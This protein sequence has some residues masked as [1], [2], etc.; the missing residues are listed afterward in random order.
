MRVLGVV[1]VML[2]AAAPASAAVSVMGGGFALACYKAAEAQ[3]AG[4]EEF[5]V[6]DRA[7][8]E[9]PLKVR[10][11]AA[12]LVNRGILFMRDKRYDRA[13]ADYMAAIRAK[14]DL[15]E[16]H[17]NHGIALV[18]MGG[19]EAE[20]IAALGTGLALNPVQPEVAFYA[21]GV[22]HEQAGNTRAAYEDYKTALS[23]K[24][25]WAEPARQLE[26]FS[27]VKKADG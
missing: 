15:A 18:H 26:R 19:R 5:A 27:V 3:R 25:D 8:N 7:L 6:C 17:V 13:V 23:I 11:R 22:A 1:T 21:R 14:R 24:P 9:E 20:A 2:L 10:D 12:T 4:E 16:A